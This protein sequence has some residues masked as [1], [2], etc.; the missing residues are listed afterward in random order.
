VDHVYDGNLARVTWSNGVRVY[1]NFGDKAGEMDGVSLE[2][3]AYKV[4][5]E[6]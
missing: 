3:G 2:K 5:T 4:V 1:L 6:P